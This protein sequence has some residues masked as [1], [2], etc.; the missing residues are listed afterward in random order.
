MIIRRDPPVGMI[1]KVRASHLISSPSI[2]IRSEKHGPAN[3]A[4][5]FLF[6]FFSSSGG[7]SLCML[8]L[9]QYKPLI[10]V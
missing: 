2:V 10:V 4:S 8:M 9:D 7:S 5:S 1:H 3:P 6:F